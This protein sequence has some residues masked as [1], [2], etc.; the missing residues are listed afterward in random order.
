MGTFQREALLV[1]GLVLLHVVACSAADASDE[2]TRQ[3]Q[4]EWVI[5]ESFVP[6][7]GTALTEEEAKSFNGRVLRIE[8]DQVAFDTFVCA[9]PVFS[10]AI[11]TATQLQ[12]GLRY[13]VSRM[14]RFPRKEIREISI[15]CKNEVDWMAPGLAFFVSDNGDTLFSGWEGTLFALR[16]KGDVEQGDLAF[17]R[18]DRELNQVYQR[19]YASLSVEEQKNLKREQRAWIKAKDKHCSHPRVNQPCLTEITLKRIQE[20]NVWHSQ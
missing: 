2:L 6:G 4:G 8:T 20:L 5:V 7:T 1:L 12:E 11:Y 10:E 17:Q 16:R 19:L 3:L 13:D 9:H 15:D 14:D 18:A